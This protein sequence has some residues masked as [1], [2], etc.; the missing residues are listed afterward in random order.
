LDDYHSII[1]PA[2]HESLSFLIDHMPHQLHIV[3]ASRVD[4]PLPVGRL[5]ARGQ[6]SEMRAADL[7]FT[8]GEVKA[9]IGRLIGY[10]L[11]EKDLDA[12][13]ARTEGWAAGLQMA[14]VAI[15]SSFTRQAGEEPGE[16]LENAGKVIASL[17]GEHQFILDYLAEEVF[18][19]Q[20]EPVRQFL[21][22]TSIL[23]RMSPSLCDALIAE[24]GSRPPEGF[25]SNETL[26][27]IQ[28]ANLFVVALDAERRWYRYHHLFGDLLQ[29][30]LRLTHPE[31][32][33]GL[34]RRAST[35]FE[36]N[37]D[38][39]AALNHA[40][41]AEDWDR[42]ANLLENYAIEFLNRGELVRVLGWIKLLPE[43]IA[44]RRPR[45]CISQAWAYAFA[46]QLNEVE[47]LLHEAEQALLEPSELSEHETHN[48][49][50]STV[51]LRVYLAITAGNPI[52]A[53]DLA[54]KACELAT[55]ENPHEQSF[56]FWMTS[57]KPSGHLRKPS[58][59]ANLTMTCGRSCWH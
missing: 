10:E 18:Q 55:G 14:S 39:E 17:T 46:N 36:Q 16:L 4:P 1:D 31:W 22:K 7:R 30:R 27:Y 42:S 59:L 11:D 23:T 19:S 29:S 8:S 13:S 57:S 45:L 5:R 58:A 25:G 37:G 49:Q 50:A 21:L 20:P 35:W 48:I 52:K 38:V 54:Q 34:H 6:L 2:I 41:A 44:R 24:S 40:L 26:D 47:A 12:L 3:V 28:K 33:S 15:R 43:D 9:L 53:V 56:L 51:I 32:I